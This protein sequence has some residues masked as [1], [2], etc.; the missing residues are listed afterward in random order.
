MGC[1]AKGCLTILILGFIC[2]AGVLGTGWY[3]FHKLARNNLISDAP[4]MVPLEQP[5]EAQYQTAESSLTKLKAAA[6]ER[7]EETVSFTAADLNALLARDPD[8]HDLE[9]HGRIEIANSTMTITLSAPLDGVFWGSRSKRRWFNGIVR[10]TG[11]YE[12]GEFD[13][14]VDSARG[15]DYE[16]PDYILSHMN[17][18]ISQVNFLMPLSKAVSICWLARL[19]AILPK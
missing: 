10:F 14:N 9:G 13:L 18:N 7:R 17:R 4:I 15:G 3:V 5:S 2:L 19:R 11:R 1:F 12:D 8:F 6:N 16:V